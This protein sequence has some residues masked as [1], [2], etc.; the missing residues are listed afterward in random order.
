MLLISYHNVSQ[1]HFF[2]ISFRFITYCSSGQPTTQKAWHIHLLTHT[3]THWGHRLHIT[4]SSG[5]IQRLLT[6][7]PH[8][9][10]MPSHSHI[11]SHSDGTAIGSN[12]S[13][14]I[15][16]TLWRGLNLQHSNMFITNSTSWTTVTP[17]PTWYL[18]LVQMHIW[19]AMWSPYFGTEFI[20]TITH[21]VQLNGIII[22]MLLWGG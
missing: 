10:S 14:S 12:S 1:C 22:V 13:L 19:K 16:R 17:K 6:K 7:V 9:V 11:H 8:D 15:S 5:T 18:P 20:T 21:I 4:C 2:P 3:F